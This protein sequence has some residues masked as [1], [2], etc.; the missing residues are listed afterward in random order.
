MDIKLKTKKFGEII[1][2]ID[3]E[4]VHLIHN[5]KIYACK[6]KNDKIY[7]IR[8]DKQWL[9]RLILKNCPKGMVIDHI[10]GDTL[11]NS[12]SNLR[13]TTYSENSKNT[14]KKRFTNTEILEILISPLSNNKL[15][16]KFDCSNCLISNIRT[17]ILYNQYFKDIKRHKITKKI[18]ENI[19]REIL[20]SDLDYNTLMNK[21][22]LSRA[23]I[24]NIKYGKS[25]NT[26]CPEIPR[27][28]YISSNKLNVGAG[29]QLKIKNRLNLI[30]ILLDKV[31]IKNNTLKTRFFIGYKTA[32][33]EFYKIMGKNNIT[34]TEIKTKITETQLEIQNIKN[35]T[36]G[37]TSNLQGG[38]KYF[39]GYINALLWLLNLIKLTSF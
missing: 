18:P 34:E 27:K 8:D 25:Y 30:N 36:I 20:L 14:N 28:I 32:L 33:M 9:H 31:N 29:F 39:R 12:R 19:I 3:D 10:N 23:S 6:L 16:K 26:I 37:L 24:Y 5:H 4:D 15:A 35:N 13:I 7:L 21:F 22:N 1:Y 11:N 2:K 38:I 17:G